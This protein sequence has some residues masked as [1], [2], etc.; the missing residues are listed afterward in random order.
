MHICL[1]TTC[2]SRLFV[3]VAKSFADFSSSFLVA[4]SQFPLVYYD[5][6]LIDRCACCLLFFKLYIERC[7]CRYVYSRSAFSSESNHRNES[8]NSTDYILRLRL[9]DSVFYCHVFDDNNDEWDRIAKWIRSMIFCISVYERRKMIVEHELIGFFFHSLVVELSKQTNKHEERD[10]HRF[11]LST[12]LDIRK[13]FLSD[14][15]SAACT[16]NKIH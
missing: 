1:I 7:V 11:R 4:Y 15:D 9:E 8:T 13:R 10:R 16:N 3:L 14:D 12:Y 2:P 5:N 6:I